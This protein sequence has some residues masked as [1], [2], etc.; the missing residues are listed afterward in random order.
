MADGTLLATLPTEGDIALGVE[1]FLTASRGG[2]LRGFGMDIRSWLGWCQLRAIDPMTARRQHLELWARYLQDDAGLA[3]ATR[4]RRVSTIKCLYRYMANEDMIAKSPMEY[5]RAPKRFHDETAT[6]GLDRHDLA[7]FIF[8][9]QNL[10]PNQ[11]ALAVLMGLLGLRVQE[12]C[13]VDVEDFQTIERGHRVLKLIGKGGKPATI[14]LPP[15]VLRAL[16]AAQGDRTTGPLLR[17]R[18]G[19]RMDRSAA[20]RATTRIAKQARL[21]YHVH[22]HMLRHSFVSNSLEAGIALR[23]VQVAARHSDPRTT[24]RYDRARHNLDRHAVHTLAA[25]IAGAA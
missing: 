16:E 9:G 14:P 19:A 2:T 22:N 1:A 3:P 7:A 17:T 15:P 13:N 24:T 11:H 20:T 8:A 5:V 10:G 18:T 21:D 25:F 12:A 23:D 4:N 6:R